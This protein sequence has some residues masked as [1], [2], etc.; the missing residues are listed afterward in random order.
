MPSPA[1]SRVFFD[2]ETINLDLWRL[3]QIANVAHSILPSAQDHYIFVCLDDRVDNRFLVM[4]SCTTNIPLVLWQ[5]TVVGENE[6]PHI[7]E[8]P[9]QK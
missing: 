3:K 6:K 9:V 4:L 5:A 1:K 2:E 8:L 7:K